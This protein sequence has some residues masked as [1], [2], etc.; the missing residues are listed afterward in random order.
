[1]IVFDVDGTILPGT[2]C[3]RLFV[4]RLV[5]E[6]VLG[7][8][9]L[10][11]FCMRAISLARQ[12]LP[13]ATKAN[14]GYLRGYSV[15]QMIELGQRY[16]R[17]DVAGRISPDA[18]TRIRQHQGRAERVILFSGMPHF[19][20]A[21]FASHLGVQEYYGSI[22]EIKSGRFTGRTIGP[23]P[24]AEGKVAVLEHIICGSAENDRP[25]EISVTNNGKPAFNWPD[26]TFYGDHWLDRF[27]LAKVGHPVAVNAADKLAQL[28][29]EK[30]WEMVKW[31]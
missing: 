18:V 8:R 2:S 16:F 10:F 13:Y 28:A 5:R 20:L 1:L 15:E 30:G 22:L 24:L 25:N 26:I 9:S 12:G 6:R 7:P 27:L 17:E 21:N 11:N 29:T 14:K 3:E 4:R 23:F 19:L 31:G